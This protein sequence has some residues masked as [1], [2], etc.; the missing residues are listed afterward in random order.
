[1]RQRLR[2]VGKHLPPALSLE[3]LPRQPIAVRLLR[4]LSRFELRTIFFII[5]AEFRDELIEFA[6]DISRRVGVHVADA[7]L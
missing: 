1:M 4:D 7:P 6:L 3:H 2:H 5:P